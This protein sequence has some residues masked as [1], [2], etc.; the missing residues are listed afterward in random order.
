V[1]E[2][3]GTSNLCMKDRVIPYSLAVCAS[4]LRE[5]GIN[6]QILDAMVENF[7]PN[8]TINRI[9]RINPDILIIAVNIVAIDIDF[10]GFTELKKKI[11][12]KI[13]ALI[14]LPFVKEVMERYPIIDVVIEREWAWALLDVVKCFEEGGSLKEIKGITFC[15]EGKLIETPLR[16][17]IHIDN[18]PIPA[19]DILPMKKYH[20]YQILTSVG[21]SHNCLFCH[22]GSYPRSGWEGKKIDKIIEEL[23]LMKSYGNKYIRNMDNEFTL[24]IEYAKELCRRIISEK[25]NIIFDGN[26][27]ASNTDEELIELLSK[28]GCVHVGFGCESGK[29][30]I[31]DLNRKELR[32]EEIIKTYKL[33]EKYKIPSKAYFLIGLFG[34]TRETIIETFEFITKKL[35]AKEAS[36][37]IVIPYPGTGFYEYLKRKGWIDE[38][39]IDNLIWIHKNVY[40]WN[41]LKHLQ[42]EKPEWRVGELT[43]DELLEIEKEYYPLIPHHGDRQKFKYWILRG[44]II[45]ATKQL[46]SNPRANLNRMV[47]IILNK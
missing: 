46:I 15:Q 34:D 38:L 24:D 3:N 4:V 6:V 26:I 19:L 12:C 47:R 13:V 44:L 10:I 39:T 21:C 27:R 9:E 18:L 35:K 5:N 22:F 17:H 16:N 37:D 30:K 7:T 23:K 2:E 28:A 45:Q 32:L 25:L 33:L 43:F 11:K 29:Q 1:T 36:F 42:G 20:H 31:L 8:E 14:N 40:N 41:N